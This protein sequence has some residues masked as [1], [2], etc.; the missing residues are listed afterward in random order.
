MK[1]ERLRT[2]IFD[3]GLRVGFFFVGFLVGSRLTLL[4]RVGFFVGLRVGLRVGFFVGFGVGLGV[5]FLVGFLTGGGGG[6]LSVLR[7]PVVCSC[8]SGLRPGCCAKAR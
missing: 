2:C 7:P 6:A 3:V 4:C 1:S 8:E 5:G